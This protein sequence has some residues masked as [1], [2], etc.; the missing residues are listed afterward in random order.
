MLS[1]TAKCCLIQSNH[2]HRG[3]GHIIRNSLP[4]RT[5][6]YKIREKREKNTVLFIRIYS[7]IFFMLF[8]NLFRAGWYRVVI[9]IIFSF[10]PCSQIKTHSSNNNNYLDTNILRSITCFFILFF[11]FLR[12][13]CVRCN[14]HCEGWK[15]SFWKKSLIL[16]RRR[17]FRP[18]V[19]AAY[20]RAR[21]T[22]RR[23]PLIS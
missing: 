22:A 6:S 11:C 10:K 16:V 7:Y 2:F 23:A 19:S 13:S 1:K 5:I 3:S 15:T 17:R 14:N 4:A 8:T 9:N 20:P 18:G 21:E 12:S